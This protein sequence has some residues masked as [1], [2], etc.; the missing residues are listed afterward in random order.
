MRNDPVLPA[1]DLMRMLYRMRP[2]AIHY[3]HFQS[4]RLMNTQKVLL[5][6]LKFP[7]RGTNVLKTA[8]MN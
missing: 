2:R 7:N 5:C 6:W 3:H 4:A 1:Y 8:L